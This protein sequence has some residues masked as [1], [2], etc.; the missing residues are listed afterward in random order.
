MR[1]I[2]SWRN[3]KRISAAGHQ[4]SDNTEESDSAISSEIIA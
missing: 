4:S 2:T 1:V 3:I